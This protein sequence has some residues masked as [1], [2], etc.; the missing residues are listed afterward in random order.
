MPSL[1]NRGV[2]ARLATGS[3]LALIAGIGVSLGPDWL[4]RTFDL[5]HSSFPYV[6][7]IP[8]AIIAVSLL[9]AGAAAWALR[10]WWAALVVPILYFAG[11]MLGALLDLKLVGLAYDAGYFRLAL[12]VFGVIFLGPLVLIALLATAMSKRLSRPVSATSV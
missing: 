12:D 8:I 10:S 2:G 9:V 1:R 11:Y 7:Y 3:L 5:L 4:A 6:G